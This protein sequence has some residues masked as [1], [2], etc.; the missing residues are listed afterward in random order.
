MFNNSKKLLSWMD[1]NKS[2][3]MK[4]HEEGGVRMSTKDEEV[5]FTPKLD[6]EVETTVLGQVVPREQAPILKKENRT[7]NR[8]YSLDRIESFEEEVTQST[9]KPISGWQ[10]RCNRCISEGI[11]KWSRKLASVSLCLFLAGLFL[12]I[13]GIGILAFFAVKEKGGNYNPID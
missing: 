4:T 2:K 1:S 6:D 13:G 9:R 3:G 8:H 10:Y 11:L 5:H 7:I 12:W